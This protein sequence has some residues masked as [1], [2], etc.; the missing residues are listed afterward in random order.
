MR[1]DCYKPRLAAVK[2]PAHGK[3]QGFSKARMLINSLFQRWN[4]WKDG[5]KSSGHE[6][7]ASH[8]V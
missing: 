3:F 5:L 6:V 8:I 7:S 4:W 1:I 2:F